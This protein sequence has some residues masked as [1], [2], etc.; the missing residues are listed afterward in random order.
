[1]ILPMLN[2]CKSWSTYGYEDVHAFVAQE[3]KARGF[4]VL[5]A[6][7]ALRD[8]EP[9]EVTVADDDP[10]FN[11]LGNRLVAGALAREVLATPQLVA[12]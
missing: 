12:H 9:G 3:A 7:S 5:D 1:V 2:G 8:R 4:A 10:H 6:S 11:A